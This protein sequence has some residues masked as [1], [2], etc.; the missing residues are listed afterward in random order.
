[1]ILKEGHADASFSIQP[2]A[3]FPYNAD[4]SEFP[5]NVLFMA[6]CEHHLSR[7]LLLPHTFVLGCVV[8]PKADGGG[9]GKGDRHVGWR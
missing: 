3:P 5:S 7:K 1:M 9:E 4:G 6:V 8:R 2:A